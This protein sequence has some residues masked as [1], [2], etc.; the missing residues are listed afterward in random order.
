MVLSSG[1]YAMPN[2]VCDCAF[3]FHI[4]FVFCDKD[5]EMFGQ[6]VTL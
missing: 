6:E 1:H 4:L 2:A 3:I 5:D